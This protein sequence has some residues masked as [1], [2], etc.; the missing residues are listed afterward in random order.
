MIV[1]LTPN[2]SLD[3]TLEID[4]L[5]RGSVLRSQGVRVEA[6]GKGVNVS[7]ALL[8]NGHPTVAVLPVG[9]PEG[10]HHLVLLGRSDLEVRPV[11]ISGSTRTNITLVEPNGVVTKINAPGPRLDAEEISALVKTALESAQGASWLAACGSLPSGAPTDVLVGLIMEARSSGIRVA[12]DSSGEPLAAAIVAGPD[13]IKPNKDELS[14]LTG[15]ALETVGDVIAAAERVR[16]RGVGS[17]LVSLGSDGAIL[18]DSDGA[19]H[20][21]TPPLVPR[22]NVGAGDATLAG[23]LAAGGSGSEALR[24]AVAWG[25][26]AVKL[27]G[28]AMPE[29]HQIDVSS[30]EVVEAVQ[31]RGLRE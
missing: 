30:V 3:R 28:T 27:P 18:V 22:S 6:G 31:D 29:P 10:D 4:K 15:T 13:V 2:P 17:V 9:G 14:A 7:R 8:V 12:V 1:T 19:W 16:N 5:V 23:F 26:A 20:A 24:T 21:C 25:A 11:C